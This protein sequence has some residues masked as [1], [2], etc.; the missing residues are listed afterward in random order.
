ML[1]IRQATVTLT[2]AGLAALPFLGSAC[3]SDKKNNDSADHDHGADLTPVCRALHEACEPKDPGVPGQINT[4]H[5]T[6]M[7]DDAA[8][9][10]E[11]TDNGCIDKCNAAPV[12]G[13]GDAG[14]SGG[15]GAGELTPVCRA[16]HEAC[17]PKDPG[18]PGDI[19]TCHMIGMANDTAK[20]QDA[21]DNMNCIE[22]CNAAPVPGADAGGADGG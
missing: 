8:K 2:V 13:E 22:K 18:L 11:A 17:M 1:A 3:S 15:G 21:T 5:M 9:C 10:Q 14:G 4:C 12:P 16:L 20:C 19:N 7:E 6:A